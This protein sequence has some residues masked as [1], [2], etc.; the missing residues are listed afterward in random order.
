MPIF[1]DPH[2]TPPWRN[3]VWQTSPVHQQT[4]ESLD[5]TIGETSRSSRSAQDLQDIAFPPNMAQEPLNVSRKLAVLDRVE[6]IE[7]L[8]RV[9]SPTRQEQE[10]STL[11][12]VQ[13]LDPD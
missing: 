2:E 4:A 13:R 7:R 5:T 9:N 8:K 12:R 3:P 11:V 10:V 6:L 1:H